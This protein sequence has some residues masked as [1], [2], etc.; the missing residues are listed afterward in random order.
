MY[1]YQYSGSKLADYWLNVFLA[2]CA[3]RGGGDDSE[4]VISLLDF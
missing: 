1:T 2:L 3:D 4:M